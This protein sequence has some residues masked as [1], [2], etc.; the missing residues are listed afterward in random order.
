[1]KSIFMLL[2]TIITACLL[3]AQNRVG[4]GTTNPESLLSVGVNSPF[5]VDSLGN[6]KKINGI[7]LSFPAQQGNN[8]TF[9]MNNGLGNAAWKRAVP[10]G[11]IILSDNINQ[12]DSFEVAGYNLLGYYQQQNFFS[13]LPKKLGGWSQQT[14]L[15]WPNEYLADGT[16]IIYSPTYDEF[17]SYYD[18]KILFLNRNGTAFYYSDSCTIPNFIPNRLLSNIAYYNNKIYVIGGRG[19]YSSVELPKGAAYS[20]NTNTWAPI[21]DMPDSVV[22]PTVCGGNGK[23]YVCGGYKYISGE[24]VCTNKLFTYDIATNN[25]STQFVNGLLPAGAVAKFHN[26]SIF[27][28]GGDYSNIKGEIPGQSYI[29]LDLN[30]LN[31][32]TLV[33]TSGVNAACIAVDPNDRIWVCYNNDINNDIF[34][35]HEPLVMS[36]TYEVAPQDFDIYGY[37][38]AVWK[39]G[40]MYYRNKT[41]QF[42]YNPLMGPPKNVFTSKFKKKIYTY[43]KN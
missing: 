35:S 38:D 12:Q 32:S 3:H 15:N 39:N 22:N 10:E 36:P 42:V 7:N 43:Q 34:F 1:M 28:I 21:A 37:G 8:N 13:A 14:V 27:I 20:I 17:A 9:L 6:F 26:D 11:G 24:V 4:V 33:N 29:I 25:W 31:Y 41:G 30:T 2:I 19:P 23:I 18:G 5:Q 40:L 16:S